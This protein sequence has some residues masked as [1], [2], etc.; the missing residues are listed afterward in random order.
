MARTKTIRSVER[1][2]HMLRV[3]HQRSPITLSQAAAAASL[4]KSSALR[5]LLTLQEGGLVRRGL[6]DGMYRIT[7]GLTFLE[8]FDAE[9]ER[10]A[11]IGAPIIDRLRHKIGWPLTAAR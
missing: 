6:A 1:A 4:P 3:L 8:D 2:I 11:E 9:A 10:F 7:T 5:I